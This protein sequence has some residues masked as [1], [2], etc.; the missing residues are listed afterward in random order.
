MEWQERLGKNLASPAEAVGVVKSGD[1][2]ALAPFTT[3][4]FTLCAALYERRN[5]LEGVRIDH[6]AGLFS[7]VRPEEPTRFRVVE[8]YATPLN[9][10]MVNS[11]IVDYLPIAHWRADE[12]APG[13]D[14]ELDA[15]LV[16][17]SPP[18]EH[19]YCSFGPGLW[20]SR[21]LAQTAKVVIA[22]GEDGAGEV[23]DLDRTVEADSIGGKRDMT[24]H[25]DHQAH[26][27]AGIDD[28]PA[29]R[30]RA[31]VPV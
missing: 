4:P 27:Q 19:G 24:L 25:L 1:R 2:V 16:P 10:E 15:F 11:G 23:A 21:R 13:F 20:F 8:N 30:R 26:E 7:W 5:E 6:P 31:C 12:I 14:G 22:V 9:R 28:R 17:V 29:P 18:D 3:T